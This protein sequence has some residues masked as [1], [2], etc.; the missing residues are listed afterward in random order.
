MPEYSFTIR[1]FDQGRKEEHYAAL[2]D[3]SAA[4]DYDAPRAP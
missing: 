1:S 3:V 4:L 2:Q